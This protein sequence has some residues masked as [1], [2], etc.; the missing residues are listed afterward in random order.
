MIFVFTVRPSYAAKGIVGPIAQLDSDDIRIETDRP[1][2]K[3]HVIFEVEGK[4]EDLD[5][6]KFMQALEIHI[7]NKGFR[8]TES[9]KKADLTLTLQIEKVY[10]EVWTGLPM[11]FG[12]QRKVR[13][14]A[15]NAIYTTD[16]GQWSKEFIAHKGYWTYKGSFYNRD[17]T[18]NDLSRAI[19]NPLHDYVKEKAFIKA[20]G[21]GDMDAVL[22]YIDGHINIDAE[23][24]EGTTA[25]I[26][27][28]KNGHVEVLQR[29]IALDANVDSRDEKG[30]SSLTYAVYNGDEETTLVLLDSGAWINTEDEDKRIPLEWAVLE[31]HD[32]VA[33]LLLSRGSKVGN[34]IEFARQNNN[35]EMEQLLTLQKEKEQDSENFDC[36]HLSG[37]INN[38]NQE[39]IQM[40]IEQDLMVVDP[41][42]IRCLYALMAAAK[43]GNMQMI[44]VLLE[45]GIDVNAEDADGESPLI[46]AAAK[47]QKEAV[48]LLTTN[49]A[50]LDGFGSSALVA[51]AMNG[52]VEV[53]EF[54]LSLA[55]DI[56]A[57]GRSGRTAGRIPLCEA[58]RAGQI[59][60]VKLLLTRGA[61]INSDNNDGK[62][63]LMTAALGG[64]TE[65][66]RLLLSKG[67]DIDL[68]DRD[69]N[70]ALDL[71]SKARL[72]NN[73]VDYRD[74]YNVLKRDERKKG[75]KRRT[76]KSSER[77]IFK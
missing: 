67:A 45:K 36:S 11:T 42:D 44:D 20:A 47:G 6:L 4:N 17:T 35:K 39:K 58:A 65:M 8:I 40:I 54:L 28:S 13:C 12:H 46:E 60:M 16:I 70:T 29:L 31:G 66:V 56:N 55:V 25:M 24:D 30:W 73:A 72:Q 14:L 68:Q 53:V 37:L 9:P 49:G 52:Q 64:R 26:A 48:E 75:E 7:Y 21:R 43:K 27:A 61:V 22:V 32:E 5:V 1:I 3:V 71:V 50:D 34:A 18:T 51:A 63:A 2:K 77:A 23:N 57:R 74:V 15:V 59:D 41:G 69:G 62:T 76:L 19:I 33:K 10:K 38:D